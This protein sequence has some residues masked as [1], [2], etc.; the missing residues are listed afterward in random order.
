MP[1]RTCLFLLLALGLWACQYA[2]ESAP[3]AP[4]QR[5]DILNINERPGRES[6]YEVRWGRIQIPLVKYANPEVYSGS[7]ELEISEFRNMVGQELVLL[8]Y[9]REQEVEVVS[10]HREP[11]SRFSSFWYSY[12]EFKEQRLEPSVAS[13]LS[14]G[15]QQG[16]IVSV[17]LFSRTDS[18]IVQSVRVK[19]ADPF[20]AYSPSVS[21]PRPHYDG[22]VF[23]FQ[24]IQESGRRPLLR[25]DTAEESTRHIYQLYRRNR[26]YKIVHV[27]G[28]KTRRRLLTDR[29]QLF[30]AQEVHH[31]ELLGSGSDWLSLPEFTDFEGADVSLRWGEMRA[32]PSSE[33]YHLRDFRTN[34][35]KELNL[36][37]GKKELPIRG[38]H[39]FLHSTDGL[40]E[41][42]VADS[43]DN[44]SLLKALY[45]ARP[46]S[47]VYFDKLIVETAEGQLMLFPV[48]FAFNIGFER[49]YSLSLEPVEGAAPE[50]ASFRMSGQ[51]GATLIRFQNYPLSR[52]LP[53]LLGVD[54]TRLQLRD[55][56]E[57][58]LLNI[59][60]TS[61]HYSLEDG[62]TFLLRE[63]QGRYGLE[64]E[65]TN[66]QEAYQLAIKDS[67]LLETFRTGAELKYI[68]YKDNANKTALLVNI[69][70]ANLSRFLTRELDVSV[71]N[72][73]NLPQNARLK[74]E[75][76][77]ASLASA[78]ESLARHGLG[79]ERIKEG[80]TVV[81]RLR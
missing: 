52:I 81:A 16:D 75:M 50:A 61:A 62:K 57:D 56:N 1:F 76:D 23:G 12:P 18:T 44:P 64:L 68:E 25:I 41:L 59:H 40:P 42:Y 39:L 66:V 8:K 72:N 22:E 71:V 4:P 54:S 29:D 79:L 6:P 15:I 80:A 11:Y 51:K 21:V 78:R 27:P 7:I 5:Q 14:Q 36:S 60:F 37:L 19:V 63:L 47:S 48:A 34:I 53:Y 33:N 67:I 32:S 77:F 74:V 3:E 45:L 31:S 2:S 24:V 26:L 58:P 49:P 28:F 65:W 30:P 10:I 70:P 38:F 9:E 46:G 35:S 17:R 55:W 20:E 13:T 69:T 73:I 43:I